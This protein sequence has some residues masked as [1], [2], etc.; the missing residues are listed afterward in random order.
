VPLPENSVPLAVS[1]ADIERDGDVDLYVSVF[2]DFPHFV[3]AT[4][5]VPAHAKQNRLLR[6]D[7]NL[8]FSDATTSAT[9]TLQNTFTSLFVD[10]DGDDYQDLVVAQNTGQV[11]I[12]RNTRDGGF[13]AVPFDSGYGFWMGVAAG[14]VDGDGDQDLAFTN[15][16][17]TFPAFA[18][19]GDRHEDQP[20]AAGWRLWR[21]D[22]GFQF[23]NVTHEAG[24][25]DLGFAWGTVFEDMNLDGRL[26]L[27]AAQNYVK[28][29]VHRWFKFPGKLLLGTGQGFDFR[30]SP[31]AE[32]RAYGNSPVIADLDGDT[33]PDLFW[34]NNDGPSRAYLNRTPGNAV[35]VRLPDSVSTLGARVRV[36]GGAAG[37]TRQVTSSSG[38]GG[39]P[40]GEL[41]FGLGAASHAERVVVTWPDG[42]TSVI[43]DPP[44]NVAVQVKAPM[45]LVS[46]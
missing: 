32:N 38:L 17:D 19:K 43:E 39:D 9:A 18:V 22:G 6:N 12:L 40:S 29:P 3:P 33:R 13:A 11:E 46:R 42:G 45:G 44:A 10:L 25:D 2:V 5:N 1:A 7:G 8:R 20:Y 24:L 21:N 26:D 34:L 4:F 27:L 36:E 28:W 30:P 14:D 41:V 35:V 15:V 16:G 31:A 37:Y 23:A